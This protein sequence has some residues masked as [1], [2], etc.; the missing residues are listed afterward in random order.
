MGNKIFNE[1][2]Q[3]RLKEVN[4]RVSIFERVCN[5]SLKT[6]VEKAKVPKIISNPKEDHQAFGANIFT[7]KSPEELLSYPLTNVPLSL[8][9]SGGELRQGSK[10][11]L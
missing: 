5:P 7:H 3:K 6:G 8:A 4:D 2:V 1:F 10:A 9:S 11:A